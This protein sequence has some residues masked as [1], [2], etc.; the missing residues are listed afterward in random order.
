MYGNDPYNPNNSFV[1]AVP[2]DQPKN[3]F[4]FGEQAIWSTQLLSNSAV[5][6]NSTE[7]L[8]STA[9]GGTGGGFT[10]PLS[11]AETNIKEGGR[12]PS[13]AAYDVF[14]I[15]AQILVSDNTADTG[16][17]DTPVDSQALVG[18]L[19]RVIQNG[20]LAWDFLQTKVDICP[21]LMAGAG[22][23]AFGSV[24]TGNAADVGHMNNGNGNIWM[25][26]KHPVSLAGS[27]TFNV[28]LQ[29]GSRAGA[30]G[31]SNSV[32]VRVA[33]LGYYKNIIE[34]G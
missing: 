8:F 25:Y 27:S 18:D 13:G 4:R 15:A 3:I 22:G 9:I 19:L 5:L 30:I 26:R 6:D 21:V 17:F 2:F 12:V 31:S 20:V 14:G 32:A 24:S 28:L 23:G 11:I 33:L 34:I 7:R 1:P 10:N 29:F 16:D